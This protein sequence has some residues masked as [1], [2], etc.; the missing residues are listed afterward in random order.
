VGRPTAGKLR[1][2]IVGAKNVFDASWPAVY[3]LYIP[4]SLAVRE[5]VAAGL[6][7]DALPA[8]YRNRLAALRG[9]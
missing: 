9:G 1:T 3:L 6:G 5:R 7:N 4:Q 2:L 8:F